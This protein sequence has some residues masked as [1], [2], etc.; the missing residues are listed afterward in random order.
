[1]NRQSWMGQTDYWKGT[2]HK[3]QGTSKIQESRW[4]DLGFR[5]LLILSFNF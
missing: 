3:A 2:G 5:E 1:V 4:K